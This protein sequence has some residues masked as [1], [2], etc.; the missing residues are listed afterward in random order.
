MKKNFIANIDQNFLLP[1]FLARLCVFLLLSFIR[2]IK[3]GY[4]MYLNPH[5][6]HTQFNP[7]FFPPNPQ[8]FPSNEK[9]KKP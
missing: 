6:E 9:M 4:N 2:N 5:K 3:Q 7:I 8:N 1:F